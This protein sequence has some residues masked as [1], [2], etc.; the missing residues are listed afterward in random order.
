MTQPQ[1]ISGLGGIGKTQIAIEYA[2]RHRDDYQAVLWVPAD[3][4]D[5]LVSGFT[6]LAGLLNLPQK[7]EQDQ[8]LVIAAV[9]HWLDTYEQWLLI[10]DNAD[11]LALL[12]EFLPSMNTGH[13]L[14]TTRAQAVGTLAN[15]ID[16]EPMELAEGALLLLRRAKMLPT[17][18]PLEQ[19]SAADYAIAHEMVQELGGLPLALDQAAAYIEETGCGLVGYLARY[20][21]HRTPLLHRR[22]T[23]VKE[24][25]E[26]VATTWSLSFA[27]LEVSNPVAADLLRLCA[28]LHPDA[29]PEALLTEG[30]FFCIPTLHSLK[31]DLISLDTAIE[32]LRA[33]SLIRR[34]AGTNVLSIH[35]LVQAVLIDGMN[36]EQQRQWAKHAVCSVNKLFPNVEFNNWP[37]CERYLLHAQA[38]AALIA[39]WNLTSPE[40]ARLLN[41]AGEYLHARKQYVEPE[42][43]LQRALAIREQQLGTDHPDADTIRKTTQY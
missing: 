25:P 39:E 16:V 43:L 5:A 3:T 30:A 42:W 6:N 17:D 14:L 20:R 23:Q 21:S 2:Y 11:D 37:E 34:N 8:T 31:S 27:S 15:S 33:Y 41:Q 26:P 12:D 22:G 13:I 28:F 32:T 24:H 1:A 18:A 40:A 35:R 4:R 19:A 7:D 29:I 36:E 38:S 10:L 9:K